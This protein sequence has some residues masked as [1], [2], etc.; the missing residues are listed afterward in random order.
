MKQLIAEYSTQLCQGTGKDGPII[1][2]N[3]IQFVMINAGYDTSLKISNVKPNAFNYAPGDFTS[4]ATSSGCTPCNCPVQPTDPA[5]MCDSTC[6]TSTAQPPPTPAPDCTSPQ[7]LY[8]QC[9]GSNWNGPACC[10]S[11]AYCSSQNIYYSQCV[12][13]SARGGGGNAGITT[14][15]S[16][17]PPPSQATQ[18]AFGQCGGSGW[19]GPTACPRGTTCQ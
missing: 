17:L 6:S 14:S 9:G 8:G 13:A 5:S 10:S 1:H 19:N 4:S 11:G 3:S 12:T 7:T 16:A 15:T 2:L 18:T